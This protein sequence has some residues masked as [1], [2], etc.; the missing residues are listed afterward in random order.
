MDIQRIGTPEEDALRR[1]IT[2]NTLFY[3]VHT[4]QIEDHTHLGLSDLANKLVRTPL[5]P[6]Q[7]FRD[8]PLRVLRCVRFASRFGYELVDELK[9]AVR[10]EEILVCWRWGICVDSRLIRE[11]REGSA[12]DTDISRTRGNRAGE[13]A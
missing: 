11:L 7:T 8:D 2:I 4:R 13:N 10:N 9:Q 1:D 12:A 6:L 5:E 3:N